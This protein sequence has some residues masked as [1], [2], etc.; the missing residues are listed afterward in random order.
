MT[1]P[2]RWLAACLCA[3]GALGLRLT[4]RARWEGWIPDPVSIRLPAS[5]RQSR[6]ERLRPFRVASAVSLAEARVA[7]RHDPSRPAGPARAGPACLA[8]VPGSAFFPTEVGSHAL[9]G[10]PVAPALDG[11]SRQVQGRAPVPEESLEPK[12]HRPFPGAVRTTSTRA[13]ASRVGGPEVPASAIR[14][15]SHVVGLSGVGLGI[16]VPDPRSGCSP[17]LRQR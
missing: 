1:L 16:P 9:S 15:R 13:E 17:G 12:L 11:R 6:A 4:K 7:R 2:A 10:F 8:A 3:A 5:G 14:G